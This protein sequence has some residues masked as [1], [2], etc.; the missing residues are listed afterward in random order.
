MKMQNKKWNL[1]YVHKWI[2][3]CMYV[4]HAHVWCLRK[5]ALYP[6]EL[7]LQMTVNCHVGARNQTQV[8]RRGGESTKVLLTTELSLMSSE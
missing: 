7:E 3:A 6:Q 5:S 8:F 4:Y 1:F 2:F